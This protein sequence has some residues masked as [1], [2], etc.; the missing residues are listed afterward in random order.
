[1]SDDR[2]DEFLREAARAYR[3]PPEPPREEMWAR[4]DAAR[5]GA[6]A[7]GD[8]LAE[9]RRRR[10]WWPALAAA[11]VLILG[12]GIGR[13]WDG[14]WRPAV[15]PGGEPPVAGPPPGTGSVAAALAAANHLVRVEALLTEYHAGRPDA[16]LRTA[17]RDL[18]ARTRLW[19]D[20]GRVDD[21]ALRALLEDLELVLVQLAQLSRDGRGGERTLIDEGLA[22]RHIRPRLRSAI[23]AGPAA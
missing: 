3:R 4:I 15:V 7:T 21:P 2:I 19:L 9:R 1:M 8:E 22:E 16:E 12:V 6:S 18:L 5:R 14:A 10:S 23:P 17:A 13:V 20:A 11:A